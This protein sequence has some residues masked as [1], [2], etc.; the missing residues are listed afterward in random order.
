[1]SDRSSSSLDGWVDRERVAAGRIGRITLAYVLATTAAALTR[2]L[3]LVV[4]ESWVRGFGRLIADN[5]VASLLLVPAATALVVFVAAAP[6]TSAFV[7][8]AEGRGLR[9]AVVHVA[10]GSVIGVATQT[11]LALLGAG[12]AAMPT[13]IVLLA[14]LAGCA[15]GWVY[16]LIAV[17]SAP[18]P[19]HD[20]APWTI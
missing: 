10:A 14:A 2:T 20:D 11:T 1:M 6:F 7:V 8:W 9:S 4:E 12:I 13:G 3:G 18:P 16:W 15:G 19:P 5:G 17:R